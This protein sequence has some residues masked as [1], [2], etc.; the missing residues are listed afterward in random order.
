[1][2]LLTRRLSLSCLS[3]L[4]RELVDR[5]LLEALTTL[6]GTGEK[7]RTS[8]DLTLNQVPLPL[9]YTSMERVTE[10]DLRTLAVLGVPSKLPNNIVAR[11]TDT[12]GAPD[13]NR[14]G[15]AS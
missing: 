9:G 6:H 15:L 13:R 14:T 3:V 12:H 1:M 5:F 7:T 2:T 10:Y 4:Q 8:T 11:A